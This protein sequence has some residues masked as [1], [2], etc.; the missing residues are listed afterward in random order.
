MFLYMQQSRKMEKDDIV[1]KRHYPSITGLWKLTVKK[2][3]STKMKQRHVIGNRWYNCDLL[4]CTASSS[5]RL[6]TVSKFLHPHYKSISSQSSW[7]HKLRVNPSQDTKQGAF[8]KT[9]LTNR[10][11]LQHIFMG[12]N[13][14]GFRASMQFL[15]NSCMWCLD[16]INE[17]RAEMANL[18]T[19]MT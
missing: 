11:K 6:A 2:M 16:A 8:W 5:R 4:C 10:M 19:C 14:P 7:H 18:A 13:D 17:N 15:Q 12:D 1:K 3:P 9:L